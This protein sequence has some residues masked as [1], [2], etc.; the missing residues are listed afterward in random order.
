MRLHPIFQTTSGCASEQRRNDPGGARAADRALDAALDSFDLRTL[1]PE[2][3]ARRQILI[4]APAYPVAEGVLRAQAE[5][6][7]RLTTIHDVSVIVDGRAQVTR[8]RKIGD[9]LERQSPKDWLLIVDDDVSLSAPFLDRFIAA[10]EAAGLDI[11]QPAHRLHSFA[12]YAVTQRKAGS[13]VRRTNFIE[14]G[15]LV[16]LR[17]SMLP[18]L[19]PLPDLRWGWGLDVLWADEARR[20]GWRLGVVDGAPMEHCRPIR[21]DLPARAPLWEAN[22]LLLAKRP[23]ITR[24]EMLDGDR[25]VIPL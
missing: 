9:A 16:A 20:R 6:L 24:A 4:V 12:S 8:L 2:M 3:R 22:A 13:L 25:I 1:D 11:A 7:Q 5:A 21:F 14:I 19:L 10:A 23:T 17:S 15:P 18:H